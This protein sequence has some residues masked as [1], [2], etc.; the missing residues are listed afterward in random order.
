MWGGFI[1]KIK[2]VNCYL[3]LRLAITLL[4]IGIAMI[5]SF[6]SAFANTYVNASD[7]GMSPVLKSNNKVLQ[8]IIDTNRGETTIYIP[9]GN[10][11]FTQGAIILHSNIN[12]EFQKGASFAIYDNQSLSFVYPSLYKGYNGGISNISW[13]NGTFKGSDI[14]GQSSF[15]QSMNH[16]QNI[17]F[18]GCTFNNV[19]NSGG[20][21]FDIDGSH[22]INI[23]NSTFLGFN[24]QADTD[25]K[26]AIQIDY[27]NKKA[28]TYVFNK[29]KYD[30]LP[31]YDIYVLNNRFLP[32]LNGKKIKYYAPN[33]IGEH[34]IYDDAKAGIIHDIHFNDNQVVDSKPRRNLGTGTINFE[35]VSN[36]YMFGNI[37]ENQGVTGPLNYVRVYNPLLKYK[38][39]GVYIYGNRFIN[40][41]PIKRYI[42]VKSVQYGIPF[43]NIAVVNNRIVT[44]QQEFTFLDT[45]TTQAIER[46]NEFTDIVS[47]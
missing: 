27:S 5:L 32:I 9:K 30:D 36:L 7:E 16:A 44:T 42:V 11:P 41:D 14:N 35:G 6:K 34:I 20:H 38:M 23:K 40:V 39:Q 28:M 10:Y 47:R 8:H 12:F 3:D 24:S 29:D 18:D 25:Y 21:V 22:G 17:R 45:G 26:E 1:V 31:S 4:V 43:S 33:P 37:F 46:N 2:K 15:T 13:K 19:E